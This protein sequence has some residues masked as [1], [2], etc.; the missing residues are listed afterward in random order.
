VTRPEK[1]IPAALTICGNPFLPGA[2]GPDPNLSTRAGRA[3]LETVSL[4]GG[5]LS[6]FP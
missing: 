6:A 4:D 2:N 3:K 1:I 5:V